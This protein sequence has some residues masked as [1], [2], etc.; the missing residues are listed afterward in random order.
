MK[1]LTYMQKRRIANK[2]EPWLDAF[3]RIV[4][5]IVGVV[6]GFIIFYKFF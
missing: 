6:L 1:K 2:I 3:V 5:S 4:A